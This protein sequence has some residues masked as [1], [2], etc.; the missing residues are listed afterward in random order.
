MAGLHVRNHVLDC[1]SA[2]AHDERRIAAA[3]LNGKL[4]TFHTDT[5]R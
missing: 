5:R 3:N 1:T 4:S 2:T